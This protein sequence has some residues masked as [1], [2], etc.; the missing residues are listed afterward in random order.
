M[1]GQFKSKRRSGCPVSISLEILGD[2]WSLLIVR[3][4]M[5]RGFKTFRQFQEAGEGISTNILADRLR[6]LTAAGVITT[7]ADASDGR[8][9]NYR[10]TEKG[11]DLAPVILDL[12]VWAA[13]HEETGAACAVIDTMSRDRDHILAETTRRWAERDPAPLLPKR[14]SDLPTLE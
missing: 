11:I 14:A 13:R 9:V 1:S 4:L 7:E 12:L 3:D 6:R 8:K 10:L 5:V 2:R